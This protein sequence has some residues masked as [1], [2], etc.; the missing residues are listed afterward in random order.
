MGKTTKIQWTDSTCNPTMG[1]EGCELWTPKVKKCYAGKMHRGRGKGNPGFSPTFEQVTYWPGRMAKAAATWSDLRGTKRPD[2]PWLNGLP[3]LIFVSDM[4][5]ALSKGVPFT[6]LEKEII[7]N[8]MSPKGQR[9]CW[10]W[11][12]KKPDRMVQFSEWLLKKGI[13]W[14]ENLWAGTS[15]T[16]QATTTR[17]NHLL[18][19]GNASTI[20]FLSVEPQYDPIDL[21]KWVRRLDWIIQGGESG[22]GSFPFDMQWARKLSA[23]CKEYGIPY[24]LK[25]LGSTVVDDG[26]PRH[27][28]DSKAGDWTEWPR[29]LRVRQLPIKGRVSRE[30]PSKRKVKRKTKAKGTSV[31]KKSLST[32]RGSDEGQKRHLAAVKAWKTRRENETKRKH[33]A[34]ALKAWR[35]RRARR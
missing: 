27:F 29:A 22:K 3:R 12:T 21:T 35:T 24:F 25:Q 15:I 19:V 17:L 10:Q 34:A 8:V 26:S 16:K 32:S 31:A 33:R 2:K 14:P 9:H 4:S 23:Q 28:K 11:L 1:C 5:D 18:R 30:M 20:R 6:F 7:H 13:A